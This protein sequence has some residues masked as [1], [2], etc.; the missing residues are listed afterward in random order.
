[1]LGWATPTE[2][3]AMGA[4]GTIILTMLYRTFRLGLLRDAF[5]KAL[6]VTA[7]IMTILLGGMMFASIFVAFGVFLTSGRMVRLPSGG[8][9][10]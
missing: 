1:M 5:L 2:A 10:S 7:M 3:G 8:F 6:R 4:I 9:L